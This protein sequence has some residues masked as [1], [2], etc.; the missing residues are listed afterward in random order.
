MKYQGTHSQSSFYLSSCKG[1]K[2]ER[3]M[4]PW[5]SLPPNP[6]ISHLWSSDTQSLPTQ[7]AWV[8]F[9]PL[10]DCFRW[11]VW[12]SSALQD[13]L[14]HF[15]DSL[16]SQLD[17]KRQTQ[18]RN[19]ASTNPDQMSSLPFRHQ[20]GLSETWFT[21]NDK[22]ALKEVLHPSPKPLL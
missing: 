17:G 10:V 6:H 7:P 3:K 11:M 16:G 20:I 9:F 19:K 1:L 14:A 18:H 12:G 15:Y 4:L 2:E 8:L 13:N 5:K 22:Q 21:S